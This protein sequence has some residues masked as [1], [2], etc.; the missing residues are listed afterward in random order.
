MTGKKK[1][2][3]YP[4]NWQEYKD[5]EDDAFIPHTFDELMEWKV[6]G[7]ELPSSISCVIRTRNTETFKVKEY[8]YQKSSAARDKI[9]ALAKLPNLEITICDHQAIHHLTK[10]DTDS[11]D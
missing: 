2:P 7:W 6:G 10:L 5:A 8:V 11:D 1:T 9:H 4:N 3:Y